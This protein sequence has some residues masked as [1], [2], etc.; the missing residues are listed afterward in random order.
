MLEALLLHF[1]PPAG[2]CLLARQDG[3]PA[4]ILMLKPRAEAGV[5]E[6]NRMFVRDSARGAGVARALV[7][8]L[9]QR[10]RELGYQVMV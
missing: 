2:E 10:A 8:R 4:G 9:M 5:F 6:M 3:H 7:A 1:T